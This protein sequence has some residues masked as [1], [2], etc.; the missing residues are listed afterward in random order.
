MG[1]DHGLEGIHEMVPRELRLP[2]EGGD[3]PRDLREG[4]CLGG[5]PH[6]GIPEQEDEGRE[7]DPEVIHGVVS[8]GIGEE[9]RS[10]EPRGLRMLVREEVHRG[11]QGIHRV[12]LQP[13]IPPGAEGDD[14]EAY[15][16]VVHER[17]HPR[18]DHH[19]DPPE[20]DRLRARVQGD[21]QGDQRTD[22]LLHDRI[23]GDDERT[24]APDPSLPHDLRAGIHHLH[25]RHR[26]DG[27]G[28]PSR[29]GT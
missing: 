13:E 3:G 14:G 16:E 24:R 15:L 20:E 17:R 6:D 19:E 9:L 5:Q 12:L 4:V 27:D 8:G 21:G 29:A 2:S 11:L 10:R 7:S 22:L 28:L 23:H 18:E 26:L 1:A 25:V